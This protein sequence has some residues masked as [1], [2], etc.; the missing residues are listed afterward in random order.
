[1]HLQLEKRNNYGNEQWY[2]SGDPVAAQAIQQLTGRR[3]I[4][5][6]DFMALTRLDFTFGC[7]EC[8]EKLK[9]DY[10]VIKHDIGQ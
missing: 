9:D 6:S 5:N 1:M 10:G 3:T 2:V 4:T 8:G 7:A